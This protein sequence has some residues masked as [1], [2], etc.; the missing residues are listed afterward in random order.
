MLYA[1]TGFVGAV[2][3]PYHI[4][5]LCSCSSSPLTCVEVSMSHEARVMINMLLRLARPSGGM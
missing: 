1:S 3:T 4:M 5:N 2:G